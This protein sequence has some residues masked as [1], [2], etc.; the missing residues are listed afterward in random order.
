VR[1]LS[2]SVRSFN[3]I[4]YHS[5][6]IWPHDNALLAMGLRKY[7]FNNAFLCI[8]DNL[9]DAATHF[10]AYRLPE[11]FAGYNRRPYEAPVP[12]PVACRPQAWSAGALPSTLTAGLGLVPDGL[13]RKLRIR[14]PS[15]PRD[16]SRLALRGLRVADARVDL[17]FQ[18]VSR[19][20][21]ALT[22]VQIDGQ[23][24]VVL[25]TPPGCDPEQAPSLAAV[26][27]MTAQ[28]GRA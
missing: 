21:V 1:T 27:A 24:D 3:P 20:A 17:L 28:A 12:Y 9:I 7:G 22:D 14:R 5:G 15:L 25:E 18:R 13:A 26:R 11:L 4:G 10:P 2:S 6:T 8:F 16:V 23:L 19:D